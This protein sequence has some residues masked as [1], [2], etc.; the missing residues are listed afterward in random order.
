MAATVLG[1]ALAA[2]SLLGVAAPA[3]AAT[4]ATA[5]TVAGATGASAPTG[6]TAGVG[7][8][9]SVVDAKA[10]P[11][12]PFVQANGSRLELAGK[13]YEFAGTNTYYLGYKSPAMVDAVLD[14]AKAAGFDVIRTWGSQDYQNPDGTGSV[15][16]N[17]E[18]VWYQAW[19]AAAG[20][21]VVNGGADGLER[22][23]LAVAE[24][25]ERGLK[26]VIPF[27]NN[28]NAFGGMD[29]YVRWAGL[30]E[31]ADF[32]TDATVRGWFKDWVGTLLNRTNTVTGVAY[33][34]DPTI[35]AWE[36]ANEPRCTSAGVYPDGDCDTTTITGWAAEMSA[37]VKSIDRNHL[38][39]AGDEGF[40]CRD[41]AQWTLTQQYGESG[42]GAGFGEDCGDGVDTVALASLPAIDL[43]SM[44]LYP[45]HWKVSTDWGT[46]WIREHAAAA[47][48]IGKPVYL[49]E[50]GI[51]D[52]ATRMPVYFEWL[53][54][55][56]QTG[57]DGTLYWMLASTQD[58]GTPYADYDGFTV[59]CPSPVCELMTDQAKLVP[60]SLGGAKTLLELIADHDAVTMQRDT[61]VAVDVLANDVSFTLPVRAKTLDL[62]PS[63][64]GRQTSVARVGGTARIQADHT[65]LVT[66]DA[67]FAGKVEF[68]YSVGNAVDTAKATLTVT[69]KPAPGDPVV[70][71]SWETGLEGW[72]PANWQTDPGTVAAGPAGATDGASALQVSSKGAWFGSP[73][74][75]P[76]LDLSTKSSLEFDIT[77]A[78]AG[79]SVSIAVRSGADWSWCQSPWT[80]VPEHTSTTVTVPMETF[81]CDATSLTDVHDVLV[82][83]NAGEYSID[84][85]T[86]R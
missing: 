30:D 35:L 72:A 71:A 18:G 80:W 38:L 70:L 77:T 42:Y 6:T 84:R 73:A 58:D 48:R 39:S 43:M 32:Y 16:Q 20:R 19:D 53:Q 25:G 36:L 81:G 3:S 40:F 52:Q 27:T 41:E 2:S 14:D 65:V 56:R 9:A 33:K 26:L 45:D 31:H 21:P 46:G 15:H 75:S 74:D 24:A 4:A 82:Y 51:T 83:L 5:A 22:L 64:T 60:L 10:K 57:V 66:P 37:Y 68:P 79:T 28:W 62:D 49:G 47:K 1:A 86:L 55:I 85:L 67:G 17:F 54:T 29:Q 11:K 34:D 44:H 78:A 12:N 59:Y 7:A 69:V 50:F 8:A 13:T 63:T 23:D 61:T 76:L